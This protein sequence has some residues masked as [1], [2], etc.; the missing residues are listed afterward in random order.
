MWWLKSL[1][2][3][4]KNSTSEVS[5]RLK[6]AQDLHDTVA[7][8]LAALGYLCDEAISLATQGQERDSLVGIRN[9]LTLLSTTLRDEIGLLRNHQKNLGSAI[10][11]FVHELGQQAEIDVVNN[12][13]RTL[14]MDPEDELDLYRA[15][16]EILTNIYSHSGATNLVLSSSIGP[17]ALAIEITDNGIENSLHNSASEFHF[18]LIG[19]QERIAAVNGT[20]QYRRAG[21]QNSYRISIPQ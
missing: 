5:E 2:L 13:P 7:Q 9:R 6:V 11:A 8:E 21:L 3:R 4:S 20:L 1:Q 19:V 14:T 10:D 18:G 12:I 17:D 16:R 15:I